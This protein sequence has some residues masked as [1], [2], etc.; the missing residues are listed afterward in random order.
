MYP[1]HTRRTSISIL[2]DSQDLDHIVVLCLYFIILDERSG[3]FGG[4]FGEYYVSLV[5]T[6]ANE[7]PRREHRYYAHSIDGTDRFLAMMIDVIQSSRE[8]HGL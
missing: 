1:T 6:E 7:L 3:I 2:D 4:A 8:I 5:R